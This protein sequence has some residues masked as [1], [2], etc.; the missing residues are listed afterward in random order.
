MQSLSRRSLIAGSVSTGLGAVALGVLAERP[1]G[2]ADDRF[3]FAHLTD[4]HIHG[5][6][7][8]VRTEMAVRH[9]LSHHKRPEM[10]LT[11]GD[12]IF[13]AMARTSRSVARQ[14]RHFHSVFDQN[15]GVRIEHIIG[16]HDIWGVDRAKCGATGKE[17]YYGKRWA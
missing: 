1:G 8:R 7:P 10:I 15:Y 16:N 12:L 5:G 2:R 11:G 14:W 17:P 9:A 4:L 13:D 6:P 3:R